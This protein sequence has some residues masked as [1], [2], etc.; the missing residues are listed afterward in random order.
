MAST[1]TVARRT[2]LTSFNPPRRRQ[3]TMFS[4]GGL[5][6]KFAERG[7]SY[8]GPAAWNRLPESICRTSS[9]AAFKRQLNTFLFWDTFNIVV[10]TSMTLCMNYVMHPWSF[11]M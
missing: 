3:P 10:W 5:C 4:R 1:I 2:S 9:Q 8:A 11:V 7:F 6:T